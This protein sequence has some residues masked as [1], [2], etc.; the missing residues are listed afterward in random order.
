MEI[1]DLFLQLNIDLKN[2]LNRVKSKDLRNILK[3][4]GE[5]IKIDGMDTA[6]FSDK[7][8]GVCDGSINSVG[9]NL[10]NKL[11]LL[12]ALYLN[13]LQD[14]GFSLNKVI[15]PL[16][17]INV[18]ETKELSKLEVLCAMN[19]IQKYDSDIV[20]MDGGFI[21]FI[22]DCENEFNELLDIVNKKN[23]LFM[24]VIEDIK[25]TTIS[26]LID[27]NL[28]DREI[29]FS[30]LEEGEAYILNTELNNKS[31]SGIVSAFF[32]P[33]KNPQPIGVDIPIFL[34]HNLNTCLSCLRTLTSSNSRGVPL[35]LDIVDK[36]VR[37]TDRD[38]EYYIK[39]YVDEDI[40]RI[41]L[42]EV[43][44]GRFL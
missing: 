42:D 29:V 19:A 37:V 40:R 32:R 18:S 11:F 33:G 15:T 5:F 31:K 28:Y 13:G 4:F 38:I 10:P 24:G 34:K 9:G 30:L 12:R 21:R 17:D 6:F 1:K 8:L 27:E 26:N 16:L 35:V 22:A 3:D 20:F 25:S 7:K 39:S 44:K 2:K 14:E 41:F 23:I 36:K 43:R